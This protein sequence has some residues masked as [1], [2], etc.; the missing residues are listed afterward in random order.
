M[1]DRNKEQE[2]NPTLVGAF[3]HWLIQLAGKMFRTQ[4]SGHTGIQFFVE[5][6]E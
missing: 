2:Q 3:L 4:P 6:E 1:S 5:M